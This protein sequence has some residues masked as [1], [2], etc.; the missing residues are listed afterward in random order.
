MAVASQRDRPAVY[1]RRKA[2]LN[3]GLSC[4][5]IGATLDDFENHILLCGPVHMLYFIKCPGLL[6]SAAAH[7]RQHGVP[8]PHSECP[9]HDAEN[10]FPPRQGGS[11]N[12]LANELL[13]IYDLTSE[14]AV[15]KSERKITAQTMKRISDDRSFDISFWQAQGSTAIF[16]AAWQRVGEIRAFRGQDGTEPGLLRSVASVKQ[17]ERCVS[18]GRRLCRDVL[19]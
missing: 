7:F 16:A 19:L 5:P 18:R 8:N 14:R 17:G 15:M 4:F 9:L 1:Q 10:N 12:S 11:A 13:D 2:R 3:D 6:Y